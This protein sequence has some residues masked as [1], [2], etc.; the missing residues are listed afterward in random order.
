MIIITLLLIYSIILTII[1]ILLLPQT[2]KYRKW[3]LLLLMDNQGDFRVNRFFKEM[4]SVFKKIYPYLESLKSKKGRKDTYYCFEFRWLI[5]WKF[6]G[7]NVLQKAL[8]EYN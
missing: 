4:E 5:W 6:F 8:R 2:Y 7:N 3:Y 1:L